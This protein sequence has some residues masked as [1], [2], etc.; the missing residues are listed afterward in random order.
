MVIG[1]HGN[2]RTSV[3]I[4]NLDIPGELELDEFKEKQYG[5]VRDIPLCDLDYEDTTL[6]FRIDR[7]IKD[8]ADSIREVGQQ[9]PVIVRNV[10]G[11]DKYQIISGFRRCRALRSIGHTHAIAIVREDLDDD[12]AYRLSF[13]EN[14]LRRKLSTMDIANAISKLKLTGK[15]DAEVGRIFGLK[16]RQVR[17]YRAFTQFRTPAPGNRC[18]E[19]RHGHPRSHADDHHPP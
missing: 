14:R 6:E 12:A 3:H 7:K 2:Q 8:L 19:L 4:G 9:I 18:R 5:E 13:L 10:P 16:E 15:S 17:N 1:A 11:S